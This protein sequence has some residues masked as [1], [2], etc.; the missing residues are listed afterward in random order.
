MPTEGADSEQF[1]A[2]TNRERQIATLICRG[3]ANKQVARELGL[4]EGTIKQHVH[5]IFQK[6]GVR[7]RCALICAVSKLPKSART[8]EFSA[9]F[10]SVRA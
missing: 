7:N 9:D 8:A 3:L 4:S 6:L 2:L 1:R 5:N 10:R